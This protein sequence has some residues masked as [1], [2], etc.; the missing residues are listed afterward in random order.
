MFDDHTNL[1]VTQA[2][3]RGVRAT[4][5]FKEAD[6]VILKCAL[7]TYFKTLKAKSKQLL[8]HVRNEGLPQVVNKQDESVINSRRNQRG[9]N[10]SKYNSFHLLIVVANFARKQ[11]F[12]FCSD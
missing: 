6:P 2:I 8:T 10:R 7:K 5:A 1:E 9:H 12:S 4:S 3:E 11:M